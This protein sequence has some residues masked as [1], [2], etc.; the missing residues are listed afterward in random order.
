MSTA[1]LSMS[2]GNAIIYA[3]GLG[4][5]SLYAPKQSVASFG[6]LPLLI[7]DIIKI[8]LAVTVLPAGWGVLNR[9]RADSS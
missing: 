3:T 1:L 4:W 8:A 9:T 2:I 5:L 7:G 6:V